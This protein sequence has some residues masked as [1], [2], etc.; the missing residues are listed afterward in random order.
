MM[1]PRSNNIEQIRY[2]SRGHYGRRYAV[3]IE[4]GCQGGKHGKMEYFY[5]GNDFEFAKKMANRIN[6]LIERGGH[7]RAL[8]W[9]DFE[10][11]EEVKQWQAK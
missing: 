11:E 10:M 6:E 7:A 8:Q 9:R 5:E 2:L 1:E 3:K 4:I